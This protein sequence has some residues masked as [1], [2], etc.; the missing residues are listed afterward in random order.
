MKTNDFTSRK[1]ILS[2]SGSSPLAGKRKGLKDPVP[3]LK[4]ISSKKLKSDGRIKA[5]PN[6]KLS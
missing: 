4:E 6:A 1:A 2:G 3:I 5:K